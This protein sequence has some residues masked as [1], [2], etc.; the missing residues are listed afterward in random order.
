VKYFVFLLVLLCALGAAVSAQTAAID[1][2]PQRALLDRYCVT[3][4]NDRLK[5]AGL[6]LEKA[7]LAHPP[8][9]AEVWE[10][11]IRR[12]RAGT[13][14]PA[15]MPRPD[16]AAANTL[17]SYL[18]NSIDAAAAAK[19]SVAGMGPR[20]M[21]R[22]EYANAVRDLLGV[23]V[24]AS[25]LLPADDEN[26]GFDN[27]GLKTS[28]ILLERYMSAAWNVSRLAVGDGSIQ[29]SE[30]NFRARPDLSQNAHIPG[31]P[32]G[33]QG[34]LITKHVFPLDG[35]YEFR[36]KL[37]RTAFDNIRGL[38]EPHQVEIT[39]DGE[40]VYLGSFGGAEDYAASAK[41]GGEAAEAMDNRLVARAPVKAGEHTLAIT[42]LTKGDF[43]T[44]DRL[45][46]F[47][48]TTEDILNFYGRPHLDRLIV[49]GPF[50]AKAGGDT[51]SRRKIFVCR[52]TK[53]ADE[54][55]CA[56]K[57]I[58]GLTKQ[59]FRRPV[60]EGDMETMLTF[61]QKGRNNGTFEQGIEMAVRR[62]LSDPKF[63][64]RY[65]SEPANATPG[66]AYKVGDMELAS[67]LSF[68]LWSTSPDEQLLNLA[69]QGRLK[70]P[71]VLAQQVKRMLAD[72]RSVAL[73]NNFAGQW[74]YL[75]NLK[76]IS[77]DPQEFPEWDDNLRQALQKETELFFES[78]VQEDR[79]VN[80]LMTANYTFI[81]DRLARH[82]GIP[83]VVGGNFQKVI[84]TDPARFGLLGKGS[85]LTVT[86]YPNR[87]SAV[88]RGKFILSNI[89]GQA[90]P[91]PPPNVPPLKDNAAGTQQLSLR[92]RM[93]AH[94][95]NPACSGCH[96]M[97]DPIGFALEN[98]DGIGQ[99]RTKDSGLPIDASGELADGTK[100]S[101]IV[102]LR[103][104]LTSQPDRFA[105]VVTEKLMTYALGR[106]TD[107][108]DMPTV[109]KILKQAA[110]NGYRFS[111]VVLGI[112]ESAPFQM[113]KKTEEQGTV[114]AAALNR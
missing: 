4:H 60:T 62:I 103:E 73:T 113:R 13:M 42:F 86:S 106:P 94:R 87:T 102:G 97:M 58:G 61:Y 20:R 81:N 104:A 79:S 55:P 108:L 19:P 8:E 67:R 110:S 30:W 23:N 38:E 44:Y 32:L 100:I 27:V 98:F 70:D 99:W 48:R 69:T 18:E 6:I 3:C 92:Q 59:A 63:L 39:V 45:Q 80:D 114:T 54:I 90:P 91:T 72:S 29:P 10:K 83:G 46:P 51:A 7:D 37:W 68:F 33:T 93:E 53:P 66:S 11:V 82:Y 41:S 78:V 50:N 88:V 64:F 40:R 21:N 5:T 56:R 24:D 26:A 36:V 9:G 84:L 101:G 14:P 1:I 34:G 17:A 89:I 111:D 15:G 75:R 52:P 43:L 35:E 22:T 12:L 95:Q 16:K 65:E 71:A 109:R 2:A 47:E 74:L 28:P 112:V 105:A 77:P 107:Y 31:L 76:N 49:K 85:T 96:K 25:T 57:I